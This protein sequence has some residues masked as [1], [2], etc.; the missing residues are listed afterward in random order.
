MIE[1]WILNKIDPL[2]KNR[3]IIL[4]DPQRVIQAGAHV[5]D[6][7]AEDNNYTVL[8]CAGNLALRDMFEAMRDDVDVRVLVV[9]RSRENAKIPLFYPDLAAT[10]Q[11]RQR[12]MLSLRDFLVEQTGDLNWPALVNDRN[13]SRLILDNLPG[14]LRAY[15]YLRHATAGGSRFSDTDLYKIIL[16]AVLNIN[17]FA[18][19]SPTDIRRLCIEQHHALDELNRVLP[20]DVMTTLRQTIASAPK[21]FN[22][23]LERD[24]DQVMLAFTLSALMHQH[25]LDYQILLSNLDPALNDFKDIAPVDLDQALQDQLNVDPNRVATDVQAAELF[26]GDDPNRLAFLLRDRLQLDQ[27]QQAISVLKQERLSSLIRGLALLSLLLDLIENREAGFHQQVLDLLAEQAEDPAI[28]AL[29]QPG[30]AW[31][32]LHQVYKRAVEVYGLTALLGSYSKKLNVMPTD[33]LDITAF[34]QLWN[35]DGLNRLDYYTAELDRSLRVGGI[36]PIP[37]KAFWPEL[38]NR[39][40]Q[41]RDVLKKTL[42]AVEIVQNKINDRFQDLYQLHY[43]TWIQQN[44]SPVIFTH[45]FLPRML[46]AYWDPQ[47]GQKAVVMVFDGMRTD[48]WDEL[49]RP[50]LE[51]RY[52]I[53]ESR[54]GSAILPTETQLSR[55]AISA[56]RLP[57]E[58][59]GKE[60]TMELKLLDGW[61]KRNMGLNLQLKNVKDDDTIESGMTVRYVSD[62]LEYIIFNFTDHNLHRNNQDLSFIYHNT[63]QTII[64]EDVRSMLRELPDDALIFITSDHGFTPVPKATLSVPG[65]IIASKQDAKYRSV[66]AMK[67]PPGDLEQHLV[68][69]KANDL[70]IPTSSEGNKALFFTHLLFPRSGYTI[71]R[72][73]GP[74][75]PDR[76][77]HGGLSL[78][79][80]LVPMV[81]MGP[82]QT[83]RPLL[84]IEAMRQVG[85]VNEGQAL[86]LEL[87]VLPGQIGLPDIPLHF[88]FSH[89]EIP[90]RREIFT[91]QRTTYT[92][93]WTP[94]LGD[95]TPTDRERGEIT[96]PVTAILTYR[97]QQKTIRTSQSTT[98][99]LKLDPNR[100]RRR[101]DS[102]LDLLMGKV[103]K[104]LK[105]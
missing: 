3:L 73:G 42:E 18:K 13:L 61:L 10:T 103:P 48:A 62:Q 19:L 53:I 50:V 34:D 35:R 6:G 5:V 57:V 100:I 97:H 59:I 94:H 75:N 68:S 69:F 81:V 37:H 14:T 96:L 85:V 29:R 105:S 31:Q 79:E 40:S 46:R 93:Q 7:W 80:C 12:L 43:S 55:K 20:P 39:W 51:E 95:I 16:G 38:K 24:P 90:G 67:P 63:V 36:L 54:P 44:D 65:E 26:L 84:V 4:R 78:A 30:E 86:T 21:P 58:F 72:P 52:E 11:P 47:S 64:R 41:A 9:D 104:G 99:R 88:A 2:K 49:L 74:H 17:P 45:Q 60:S 101:V 32:T 87:V 70:G 25:G 92:F 98:V 23:L 8:F 76:Y 77:S 102:K 82:R 83:E 91:G 89:E 33:Q 15:G 28:L 71:K 1:N 66:R 27:P 56:G 22:L